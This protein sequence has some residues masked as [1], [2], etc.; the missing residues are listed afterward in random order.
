MEISIP[1]LSS[2]K[3]PTTNNSISACACNDKNFRSLPS[4]KTPEIQL[5]NYNIETSSNIMDK[6]E[7]SEYAKYLLNNQNKYNMFTRLYPDNTCHNILF[8]MDNETS[9]FPHVT[10]NMNTFF[11]CV[12][13]KEKLGIS[14]AIN[15]SYGKN[16]GI[17][18]FDAVNKIIN[19][20][21]PKSSGDDYNQSVMDDNIRTYISEIFPHYS[22]LGNTLNMSQCIYTLHNYKSN[23]YNSD[24]Y[25]QD[26]SLLYATNRIQGMNHEDA[27]SNLISRGDN[28]HSDLE[29]LLYLL[30]YKIRSELDNNDSQENTQLYH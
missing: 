25:C 11:N 16:V 4:F 18:W 13:N 24:Y 22:Y 7:Y 9:L 5:L 10:P 2:S 27:A 15:F 30:T 21:D 6:K 23:N 28:I 17:L 1:T 29:Q 20:F 3:S 26:Y 19:R 12:R 8:H 14:I